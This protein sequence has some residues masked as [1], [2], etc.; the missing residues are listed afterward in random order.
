[1]DEQKP[2]W[3]DGDKV[4]GAVA[5]IVLIGIALVVVATL[6]RISVWIWP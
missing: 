1:M 2:W 6:A 4:G 5:T 3:N